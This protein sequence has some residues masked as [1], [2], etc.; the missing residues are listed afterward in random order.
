MDIFLPDQ[1]SFYTIVYFH[2][3]GLIEGDKG[4][5]YQFCEHLAKAGF[6]V[7]TCTYSLLPNNR[8][9]SFINDAAQAVK[10]VANNVNQYG[11]SK[12][13]IISGQSAGAYLTLMLCLN[14]KYLLDEEVDLSLIKGYVSDAGQPTAHFNILKYEKNL[15]PNLQRI[16]ETAP[17]YYVDENT[18]FSRLLLLTYTNDL[19]NRLEQNKLLYSS[20]KSFDQ[21]I[22]VELSVLDGSHCQGSSELNKNNEY[23]VI[24]IIKKWMEK[25]E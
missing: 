19:P 8:F 2:G 5:T 6:M 12:G 22:D 3:G 10:Y 16:D 24:E 11:R 18:K 1:E 13:I 17:L 9:P 14:N 25:Y 7:A 21:K 20:L 15:S 23:P 4:D